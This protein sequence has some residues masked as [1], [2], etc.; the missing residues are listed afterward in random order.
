MFLNDGSVLASSGLTRSVDAVSFLFM[1]DQIANEYSTEDVI[2]GLTEWVV[3]FPTKAF[4]VDPAINPNVAFPDAVDPF[5]QAWGPSDTGLSTAC[6]PVILGI[7]TDR[8]VDPADPIFGRDTLISGIFDREEQS[9]F[10]PDSERPPI[11]SPAPPRPPAVFETFELCYETNI[12][13]F[14]GPQASNGIDPVR[15]EIFG[16]EVYTNFDNE[17]LG[18]EAGWVNIEMFTYETPAGFQNRT[19]LGGLAG[20]PVTGFSAQKF[21]NDNSDFRAFYGGIYQHKGTRLQSN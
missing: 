7:V 13:R 17:Q 16:S 6:E 20:L 19:G 18:F 21:G 8:A 3:T 1:H 2:A 10:T 14:G 4:Y 12:I 9:T 15:S 11:V 5:V